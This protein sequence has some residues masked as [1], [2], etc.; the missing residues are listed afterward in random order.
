MVE[1]WRSTQV[2]AVADDSVPNPSA[3][4]E[5][6]DEDNSVGY[7]K[8][9]KQHQFQ[10]GQSGN[11]SGRPRSRKATPSLVATLAQLM[12]REH[13][14]VENGS[15][16]KVTGSELFVTQLLRRSLSNN[17]AANGAAKILIDLHQQAECEAA[18]EAD[19]E[20]GLS[21]EISEKLASMGLGE[22]RELRKIVPTGNYR[23]PSV[24]K[25]QH[26][27]RRRRRI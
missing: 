24:P 22:L 21:P 20:P 17:G 15:R 19:Q 7:G 9:P 2:A 26:P 25:S 23:Q 18:L 3:G 16:K 11:P 4:D 1:R 12:S 14:V 13:W 5:P 10:P 6:H 8:P 27:V